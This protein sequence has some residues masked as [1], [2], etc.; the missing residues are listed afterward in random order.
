VECFWSLPERQ[1]PGSKLQ[2]PRHS[3][4]PDSNWQ[5]AL[6]SFW[7]W[8]CVGAWSLELGI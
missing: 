2:I 4:P 3:Q 1:I 5:S 7:F 6:W 8:E